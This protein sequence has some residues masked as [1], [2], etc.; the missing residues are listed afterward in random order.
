MTNPAELKIHEKIARIERLETRFS[1]AFMSVQKKDEEIKQLESDIIGLR[2]HINDLF[3]SNSS[4][5]D[6]ISLSSAECKSLQ[7]SISSMS[8][9]I[10]LNKSMHF[11]LQDRCK[12]IKQNEEILG[13]LCV[14]VSKLQVTELSYASKTDVAETKNLFSHENV[15]LKSKII[16]LREKYQ[17]QQ[18]SLESHSKNIQAILQQLNEMSVQLKD[19]EASFDSMA[20]SVGSAKKSFLNETESLKTSLEM[21]LDQKIKASLP[22]I[23]IKEIASTVKNMVKT[24][25]EYIATD[26]SNASLKYNNIDAKVTLIEKKIENI[27]LLLKKA[28]ISKST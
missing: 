16:D 28:E 22:S 17:S 24:D 9:N 25:I 10:E 3:L 1:D 11:N 23:D 5:D 26:A 7:D 14:D 27:Y 15:D 8:V 21:K 20:S 19:T 12:N 18:V 4:L 6:K 2:L 13:R